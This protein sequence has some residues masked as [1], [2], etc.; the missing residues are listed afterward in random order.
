MVEF[1][2]CV[3]VCWWYI[4]LNINPIG[5]P[6]ANRIDWDWSRRIGCVSKATAIYP[7]DNWMFQAKIY[8][9]SADCDKIFK[10]NANAR[11][12]PCVAFCKIPFAF[13]TVSVFFLL[14]SIL[15]AL[16]ALRKRAESIHR[17]RSTHI[18]TYAHT[19]ALKRRKNELVPLLLALVWA[20]LN[21]TEKFVWYSLD[22]IF[23]RFL[24]L[25]NVSH[26][27]NFIFYISF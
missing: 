26:F 17:K 20:Q 5:C 3:S 21:E 15:F 13:R 7:T 8:H 14:L 27:A 25:R 6:N 22:V 16:L 9:E 18:H 1:G 2:F 10:Q 24:S 12:A 19:R 23:V 11:N 4:H